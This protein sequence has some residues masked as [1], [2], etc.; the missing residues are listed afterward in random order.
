MDAADRLERWL[1]A[2]LS[3]LHPLDLKRE[4]HALDDIVDG[5]IAA[6]GGRL[7]AADI[8]LER[9]RAPVYVDVDAPLLEQALHGLF[10]NALEA[11]PQ[12]ACLYVTTVF[13]ADRAVL[14][15]CDQGP[16]MAVV[17]DPQASAP[18]PTTKRRGTG[19]GIP[20]AYKVIH[21][22]DGEL[23]YDSAPGGGTRVRVRLPGGEHA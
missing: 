20:F 6:L 23:N 8:T 3:Y 1:N 16:G 18:L 7:A 11:S 2:L 19:L 10:A 17:P 15:I 4:R 21:A 12:G 9:E 22:H 14:E 5:A 13:D